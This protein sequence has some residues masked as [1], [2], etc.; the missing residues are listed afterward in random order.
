MRILVVTAL[1]GAG[2]V[3]TAGPAAA[4]T[5]T[6]TRADDPVPGAVPGACAVDDCSLREAI[7]DAN[8]ND[9]PAEEDVIVFQAGVGPDITLTLGSFGEDPEDFDPTVGDLD[10][11]QTVLV[12]GSGQTI[13]ASG[14]TTGGPGLDPAPDRVFQ[15]ETLVPET[16]TMLT[17]VAL[18]VTGGDSDGDGGG[19]ANNGSALVLDGTTV[20]DNVA[21]DSGGGVYAG[22]VV[23]PATTVIDDSMVSSNL[24]GNA[25]GQAGGGVYNG[26]G[27]TL[28]VRNGSFVIDNRVCFYGFGPDC[29]LSGGEGDGGGIWNAGM[30]TV[31]DSSVQGN[32]ADN[33]GGGAYNIGHLEFLDGSVVGTTDPDDFTGGNV[34]TFEGGGIW[35]AGTDTLI[36]DESSISGNFAGSHG[37]GIYNDSDR[38]EITASDVFNNTAGMTCVECFGSGGDGGGIWTWAFFDEDSLEDSPGLF[39][40][41]ETSIDGNHAVQVCDE[42]PGGNGGGV[43]NI[44]HTE[45]SGGT[46]VGPDNRADVN[47]GGI[48]TG[49]VFTLLL[50]EVSVNG[51]TSARSG[52][53][54]YNAGDQVRIDRTAI[55]GNTA[56]N[57]NGGG[58][59]TSGEEAL[60]A[61]NT[62]ISGNA[63]LSGGEAAPGSRLGGGIYLSSGS[64][65]FHSVTLNENSAADDGG[66]IATGDIGG[67]EGFL[68]NTIVSAGDPVNCSIGAGDDV[69][70]LD[71]NLSDEGAGEGPPD[72]CGF[73]ALN[74]LLGVDPDLAD[75]F[76]NA[77]GL[78]ETHA[79]N[80]GSPAID[81]GPPTPAEPDGAACLE[82]DQRGV[83]RPQD[84]DGNGSEI[85]DRGAYERQGPGGGP[86][87]GGGGGGPGTPGTP[88]K[89]E[90]D[91][92]IIGTLG[93]DIL[94]GTPLGETICGLEGDDTILG[95]GGNDSLFGDGGDDF[96]DGGPGDDA[97][98]GGPGSDTGNYSSAPGPVDADLARQ[99]TV[100]V[101][102]ST[103]TLFGLENLIGSPFDDVLAGDAGPNELVGRNGDD[104]LIGRGGDDILRDN[105]GAD[106]GRGGPGD[107]LVRGGFD[108]DRLKGGPGDDRVTGGQ[109]PDRVIGNAGDDE[110]RGGGADDY[111]NGKQGTDACNGGHGDDTLVSCER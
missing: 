84:G 82:T 65:S 6:V 32:F 94:I 76:L 1:V 24:T 20:H 44:G 97:L 47:G 30:A 95:G 21:R 78:T 107:D 63:A 89:P 77:P 40:D 2:L 100:G 69:V 110:L 73:D 99:T 101:G 70:S 62:T 28:T 86:G 25:G 49:G 8:A 46:D 37:G 108:R 59:W 52:G 109:Q 26:A 93:A 72:T 43:F 56:E 53:G 81:S 85:C 75:L 105:R 45:I 87:G 27:D 91:C 29:E 48:W 58:I 51:N 88:V 71:F 98:V 42:C 92:D 12:D 79:L 61:E 60:E 90:R 36:V 16:Q 13:D 39:V 104:L 102:A 57:G 4:A 9:N 11:T 103:D 68:T 34:A 67:S 80:A 54:I 35:T 38:V 64:F 23:P 10:V 31:S 41:E 96:L 5:F 7:M 33:F 74:D 22:G 19:I 106:H 55:A 17:L 18:N 14:L 3:A 66:S 111:L 15:V 50:S 83:D